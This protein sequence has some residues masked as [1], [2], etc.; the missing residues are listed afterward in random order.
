MSRLFNIVYYAK[1]IIYNKMSRLDIIRKTDIIICFDGDD[2]M[3]D[4][5]KEIYNGVLDEQF[6][7][8]NFN[9]R[10]KLQ[11]VVYLLENMGVHVGN[12][13]F[14]WNK[15]GPYSIAL[16]DDAYRC[17]QE[18][19]IRSVT[20]THEAKTAFDY[21]KSIISERKV[22]EDFNWLE[23]ISS[24]HFLK[25]VSHISTDDEIVLKEL[26][27]RK[28]YLNDNKENELAMKFANAVEKGM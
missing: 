24:L 28:N 16:D 18:K 25:Y 9:Q 26:V 12:Y 22:Y 13:S 2:S 19:G 6:N 21:I 27:K 23:C 17:S 10:V 5:L 1:I 4:V 3:C 14:T 7:Y 8:D 20:F 11:K 15:Y